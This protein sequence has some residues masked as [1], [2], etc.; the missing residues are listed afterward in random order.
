MFSRAMSNSGKLIFPSELMSMTPTIFSM[1][2]GGKSAMS[3]TLSALEN[4]NKSI[5]PESSTSAQAK[6]CAV[7]VPRPHSHFVR[8]TRSSSKFIGNS[9][10]SSLCSTEETV[11]TVEPPTASSSD[12]PI[13]RVVSTPTPRPN[14]S[15]IEV[16]PSTML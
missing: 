16:V 1:S 3:A 10:T 2:Q 8:V 15:R 6:N 7:V 13:T 9:S 11:I 4:S 12:F 14:N 5:S